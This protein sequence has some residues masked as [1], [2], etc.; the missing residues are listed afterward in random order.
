MKTIIGILTIL[1]FAF[2]AYFYFDKT[3]AKC[4]DN[5]K[6]LLYAQAVEKRLDYKILSDQVDR[7]DQRIYDIKK[8]YPN[9]SAMPEIV[10][11]EYEKAV[12]DKAKMEKKLEILENAK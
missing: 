3:Y 1:A 10:K 5:S 12:V 2:G 6:V 7:K 4:E 9:P 11:Q 8:S